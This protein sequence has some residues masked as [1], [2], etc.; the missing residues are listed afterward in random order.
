MPAP[1]HHPH[2]CKILFILKKRT[3]YGAYTAGFSSGLYNSAKFAADML[4]AAGYTVKLVEVV[5]NNSIDHEVSVFRPQIVII[6]ALWVV[7]SKFPVLIALHPT[8]T[9]IVRIHSEAA[10]LAQ[11]GIAIDWISK[12]PTYPN[13]YV[14]ANSHEAFEQVS[15][16]YTAKA[17]PLPS[18][19]LL[20]PTY[21]PAPDRPHHHPHWHSAT[22]IINVACMG[23]IRPLKNT[24]IQAIAAIRFADDLG[25]K[26]R[27]HINITR[28]ES[29][30]N[31][32]YR[33]VVELF[34]GT[35]HELVQHDWMDHPE[36]LHFLRHI[37]VSL[38]VSFSETFDIVMADSVATGIPS[39]GSHAIRWLSSWSQPSTIS[40]K[41]IRD[42]MALVLNNTFLK[43]R[44]LGGLQIDAEESR[45]QWLTTLSELC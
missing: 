4:S 11:E 45:E 5:D 40:I 32:P 26:L 15:T 9:W 19:L 21:Y 29:G 43:W 30:G 3:S 39:V 12:Y 44:N 27:F 24:L 17:L 38:Q 25:I 33:S 16:F 13:V 1:A 31:A 14:A 37:D 7:P 41:S 2:R 8:V 35:R 23:A 36:F 18:Q 42:T 34:A 20:L 6:E 28:L 10:F 22:G